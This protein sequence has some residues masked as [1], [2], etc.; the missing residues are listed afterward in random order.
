MTSRFNLT[1]SLIDAV[2]KVHDDEV[3]KQAAS[4]S[5]AEEKNAQFLVDQAERI[6][7]YAKQVFGEGY[8]GDDGFLHTPRDAKA[9][10]FRSKE[11]VARY[12]A[13][14]EKRKEN[15]SLQKKTVKEESEEQLT[16]K[17]WIAGAIRRP[18]ALHRKLGVPEG[19]KIPKSKVNAAAKEG[20]TLGKE[21]RLAKTLSH[22]HHKED[23]EYIEECMKKRILDKVMK[24]RNKDK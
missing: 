23:V 10:K 5:D 3:E 22:M 18:G 11:E 20:G 8:V 1:D 15:K 4:A 14:R 24:L 2:K 9:P 21:A 17:N 7:K 12:K 19:K 16:E 6:A 13:K